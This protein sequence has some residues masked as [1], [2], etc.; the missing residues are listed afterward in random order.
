MECFKGL[1][2]G[3]RKLGEEKHWLEI[4]HH[5]KGIPL[6]NL[7]NPVIMYLH[8]FWVLSNS[9]SA[10]SP[11]WSQS[12]HSL[13]RSCMYSEWSGKYIVS[14]NKQEKSV[15]FFFGKDWQVLLAKTVKVFQSM[16]FFFS[17]KC[18][19]IALL[20]FPWICM[21]QWPNSAPWNVARSTEVISSLSLWKSSMWFSSFSFPSCWLNEEGAEALKVREAMCRMTLDSW[22]MA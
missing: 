2:F 19:L 10:I 15:F 21:V 20:G 13:L 7:L 16:F 5:N 6:I 4:N 17:W 8:I 11:D 14:Y 1:F 12:L 9:G 3:G 18:R 22:M